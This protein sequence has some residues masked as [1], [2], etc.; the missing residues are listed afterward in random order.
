MTIH[1]KLSK[2]YRFVCR[3]PF[4]KHSWALFL[5]VQGGPKKWY[6]WFNYHFGIF[7]LVVNYK[8]KTN[9]L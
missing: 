9:S 6:Y 3:S 2:K 5:D 7:T 1:I 4:H 8:Y